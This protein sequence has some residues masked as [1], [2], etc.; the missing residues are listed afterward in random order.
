MFARRRFKQQL[1]GGIQVRYSVGWPVCPVRSTGASPVTGQEMMTMSD[2]DLRH[3][4]SAAASRKLKDY[5]WPAL[6]DC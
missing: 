3:V 2:V 4:N 1:T 6:E 5:A